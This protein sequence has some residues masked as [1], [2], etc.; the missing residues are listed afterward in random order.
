MVK[1]LPTKSTD[2]F[3]GK[4]K[5][6]TLIKGVLIAY[7]ITIPFFM[8][9]SLILSYTNFPE[10]YISTAVLLTTIISIILSSLTVSRSINAKGW[11]VGSMIGFLYIVILYVFSGIIFKNFSI[12]K[13]LILTTFI[14]ITSGA[15]G[16]IIGVN[17]KGVKKRKIKG[18]Y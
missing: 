16:G 9:F 6:F 14:C 7:V 10:T 1:T 4:L 13:G 18:R 11:L 15:L 12:G 5:L 2:S 17:V 3:I 8:L